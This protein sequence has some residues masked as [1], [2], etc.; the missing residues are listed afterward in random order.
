ML[1]HKRMTRLWVALFDKELVT[2]GIQPE[3]SGGYN[4]F[5]DNRAATGVFVEDIGH[6]Y[7]HKGIT[8]VERSL[9]GLHP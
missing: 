3:V 5:S 9:I 6:L 4:L 2:P 1:L 8:E 7:K